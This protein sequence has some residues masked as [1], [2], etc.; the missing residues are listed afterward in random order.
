LAVVAGLLLSCS[1][2]IAEEVIKYEAGSG[3]DVVKSI[4]GAAYV[5][6][7]AIFAFRLFQ[8]RARFA[9]GEVAFSASLA[10]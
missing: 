2:A 4:A 10:F 8:K 3:A 1:P 5:V 7:L 6:L 9:T